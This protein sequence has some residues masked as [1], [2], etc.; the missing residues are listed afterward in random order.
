MKNYRTTVVNNNPEYVNT[1]LLLIN[2]T[3]DGLLKTNNNEIVELKFGFNGTLQCFFIGGKTKEA[4]ELSLR[5]IGIDFLKFKDPPV[6]KVLK[7]LI[8]PEMEVERIFNKIRFKYLQSIL[9]SNFKE[10]YRLINANFNKAFQSFAG[11]KIYQGNVSNRK[12]N[13]WFWEDA[14]FTRRAKEKIDFMKEFKELDLII[15]YLRSL[16]KIN[17]NKIYAELIAIKPGF[18][19]LFIHDNYF[20]HNDNFRTNIN[21]NDKDRDKVFKLLRGYGK[22]ENI[23][24]KNLKP[25][26]INR[27]KYFS[28]APCNITEGP[29]V[30][31]KNLT[32]SYLNEIKRIKEKKD[33]YKIEE[34]FHIY[35]YFRKKPSSLNDLKIILSETE[36]FKYYLHD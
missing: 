17:F 19:E 3:K 12:G 22:I 24:L 20:D 10:P 2:K 8:K 18:H 33:L 32:V 11:I 15:S 4:K 26:E 34:N 16:N 28:Y 27:M 36:K 13:D 6:Y 1:G 21:D 5:K 9:L 29:F 25:S 23:N 14:G 7:Y 30:F 35:D 31:R